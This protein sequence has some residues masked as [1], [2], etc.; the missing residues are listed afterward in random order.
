MKGVP[1]EATAV[2][3][4]SLALSTRRQY[5]CTY[6]AWWK[7][8]QEK[9]LQ[10][11]DASVENILEFLQIQYNTRKIRYGSFNSYRS[12]LALILPGVTE[13]P[14]IKR[15]LKGVFRLRPQRA[16]YNVTW[17]PQIVLNYFNGLGPNE[18]LNLEVL[19][20]KLCTLLAL[21]TS[22]RFQTLSLIK[23]HNIHITPEEIHIFVPDL[24]KTSAPSRP[25][26]YINIPFYSKE[27]NLCVASALLAYIE[28]S[29]DLRGD[30][31]EKL[32]IITK[33]PHTEANPQTISKWVKRTIQKAGVNMKIF[34]SY[35]VRHAA[36]STAYHKGVA[37]D[38]IKKT[39]G[40][41]KDSLTF[42]KF[43]NKSIVTNTNFCQSILDTYKEQ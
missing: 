29:K 12:A 15:F 31:A 1:A 43:Y 32:F 36:V 19:T 23:I 35:S 38:V 11:Y 16:K 10:V 5:N 9:S 22:Q 33:T 3:M 13:D 37:I 20:Q 42:A 41:T 14:R 39:A 28:A 7:F 8:C 2:M 27:P 25:Q 21:T 30:R 40:W 6:E 17:N 26:P 18:N 24:V 4:E 34:T